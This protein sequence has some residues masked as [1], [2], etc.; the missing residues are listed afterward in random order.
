M[1]DRDGGSYKRKG[2]IEFVTPSGTHQVIATILEVR[3]HVQEGVQI[4]E[5]VVYML[6]IGLSIS[7]LIDRANPCSSPPRLGL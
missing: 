5:N 7:L 1:P 2:K 3:H 4:C 6:F